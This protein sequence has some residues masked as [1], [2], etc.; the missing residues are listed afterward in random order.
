MRVL[1][2]LS[3]ELISSVFSFGQS[4]KSDTLA[5]KQFLDFSQD[6]TA[7][8]KEFSIGID[9]FKNVPFLLLG[10]WPGLITEG[11]ISDKVVFE[12]AFRK[13]LDKYHHWVG[14]LGY[15]QGSIQYNSGARERSQFFGW[16]GKGGKE[17]AVFSGNHAKI[18]LLAIVTYGHYRTD[19]RYKSPT[20]GDYTESREIVNAGIGGEP[21]FAYDFFSDSRWVFRW[22]SRISFHYRFGGEGSTPYYPGIGNIVGGYNLIFSGGTTLQLHYR[23]QR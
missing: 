17:S 8:P 7:S 12:L 18:G 16:Y 13:K 20:F 1:L 14:L 23:F 22:I 2:L 6:D 21:Y 5:E 15:A 4:P 11:G 19:L 10:D 9:L 3:M